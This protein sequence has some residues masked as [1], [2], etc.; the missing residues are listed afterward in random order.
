MSYHAIA[1]YDNERVLLSRGLFRSFWCFILPFEIIN[2]TMLS[3]LAYLYLTAHEPDS[4]IHYLRS[5]YLFSKAQLFLTKYARAI[6]ITFAVLG[7]LFVLNLVELI[8]F[9]IY[10]RKLSFG[11]VPRVLAP[12][13]M[14]ATAGIMRWKVV[15]LCNDVAGGLLKCYYSFGV[16]GE[17][18]IAGVF[19]QEAIEVSLQTAQALSYSR[20][21]SNLTL[22]QIYGVLIFINCVSSPII[23]RVY[24]DKPVIV[25]FLSLVVDFLIKIWWGTVM[26]IWMLL[27]YYREFVEPTTDAD[28]IPENASR[29]VQ[30]IVIL[31][32]R[33]FVFA[34]YPFASAWLSLRSMNKLL[35][36][37]KAGHTWKESLI[38]FKLPIPT[39]SSAMNTRLYRWSHTAL[40]MFGVFVL[41]SSML[42]SGILP[43]AHLPYECINRL[44]PW[45][46]RKEACVSRKIDCAVDGVAGSKQEVGEILN[47]FDQ[48]SLSI[49][50]LVNCPALEMPAEI[51]EFREL[52]AIVT[53][54]CTINDWDTDVAITNAKFP[55]LMT[56]KI[57]NVTFTDVPVGL[58][59]D[60]P[61]AS[62][63]EWIAIYQ[64][65][66]QI[67]LTLVGDHW[68]DLV[69]FYCD[70]CGVIRIPDAVTSMKSLQQIT[71]WNNHIKS[72]PKGTFH[73]SSD[74]YSFR[75]SGAPIAT[76]P[77]EV[78]LVMEW[79][80]VFFIENTLISNIPPEAMLHADN[81]IA[82]AKVAA[83][84]IDVAGE[85]KVPAETRKIVDAAELT[86]PATLVVSPRT[87][88]NFWIFIL[89][90]E[91]INVTVLAGMS[92]LYLTASNPESLIYYLRFS[93]LFAE[94]QLFLEDYAAAIGITFALLGIWFASNIIELVSY[95][96]YYR[97]LCFGP[98]QVPHQRAETYR[99]GKMPR[100]CAALVFIK[101]LA[102]G[103][104]TCYHSF[105][106]RG[107]RFT[108]GLFIR[109]SVEI[110]LQT[111]QAYNASRHISNL[112]LNQIYGFLIFVNCVSSPILQ[113]IY[114]HKPVM[115]RF[116]CMVVDFVIELWWGMVLP[117]WMLLPFI[118]EF[119]R[120]MH[121]S[122]MAPENALREVQEML[123]LSIPAYIT[124]I[125]PFVSALLSLR[126]MKKLL[127]LVSS[128]GSWESSLVKFEFKRFSVG[129]PSIKG[130]SIDVWLHIVSHAILFL[131]G[132]LV[133][134]SSTLASGALQHSE[135]SPYD[136]INRLHP[137]FT[138]KEACVA[139]V[140]DCAAVGINGTR[141]ELGDILDQF[142]RP[143]LSNIQLLNCPELS[144][145][146]EITEFK[147]LTTV[148]IQNCTLI[149]W[150]MD[151]SLS[152][153]N[154]PSLQTLK[155]INVTI[156]Q[157]PLGFGI[158]EPL[159]AS[160]EW[161][162]MFGTNANTF[163]DQIQ[164]RW[165]DVIYL[166]WDACGFDYVPSAVTSMT[167]LQQV[168]LY[169]NNITSIPAGL[170][171]FTTDLY[172]FRIASNPIATL[173]D[174]IWQVT[175]WVDV[176]Y[177][178]RTL[179]AEL[180]PYVDAHHSPNL[181]I[182]AH[183]AP[184]CDLA[185]STNPLPS[186]V[187]CDAD[188]AYKS[189]NFYYSYCSE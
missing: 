172:S 24:H 77:D 40:V 75:F 109:E 23:Q 15:R 59:V 105:G 144:Y 79:V 163:V 54:N 115:V 29:E 96:I 94:D 108:V 176:F 98:P 64:S 74:L 175:A 99:Y 173:P 162:S 150:D 45:F 50:Q 78:W 151:A 12:G 17:H 130:R 154:F 63:V 58:G 111:N 6:G 186:Y 91:L 102:M 56:I 53:H 155:I 89:L 104:L 3:V 38:T 30:L 70:D 107:V 81:R 88:R 65:N 177:I 116:L 166:Y 119:I 135:Q 80:E 132:M 69:Y 18:F 4:L 35:G 86:H 125:Y 21:L 68:K 28:T 25:R 13:S 127:N 137:W 22:N 131:H 37:V 42:T 185:N 101:K 140:I 92:Y 72:V 90:F 48:S 159:S 57:F 27:P 160:F 19:M 147:E 138:D 171:Q 141:K 47:K 51:A 106:V 36:H 93:Y 55:N 158:A 16:R 95:S 8:G 34:V 26:P 113:H 189:C 168:T 41:L 71:F 100:W 7:A 84:D 124:A 183:G 67:F 5:G 2:A 122:N 60:E 43:T 153:D 142:D 180:P 76:L 129:K 32:I 85:A 161:V 49:L 167:Q 62:N 179:I 181:I 136:C 128:S 146:A 61:L 11:R 174:D 110:V 165:A 46:T 117:I 169:A 10:H 118:K 52:S 133:I 164:T 170:F 103:A 39:P 134:L 139:R 184:L 182:Y 121:E 148:S 87:F 20:Q 178:D 97:R 123:I 145:P 73:F 33:S 31:T 188:A 156:T 143:S 114:H 152:I 9:S 126:G 112:P 149:A 66:A 44:H 120:P 14:K 1:P 83:V 187:S 82:S 157:P